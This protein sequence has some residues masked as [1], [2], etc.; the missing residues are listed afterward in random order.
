MNVSP[1]ISIE[2]VIGSMNYK[3]LSQLL[4]DEL[5]NTLKQLDNKSDI[6]QL[7]KIAKTLYINN[8]IAIQSSE[9]RNKIIDALPLNKAKELSIKLKFSL[10]ES[11]YKNLKALEW[12]KNREQDKALTSFFGIVEDSVMPP[13]IKYEDTIKPS[14]ALFD[15]QRDVVL[16]T[17][18]A[19]REHPHKTLLHMPTGSGKTRSSMHIIS[20]HLLEKAPTLVCWLASSAELLEQAAEEAEK[21]WGKIGDREIKIYRFWGDRTIDL[22]SVKDGILVAGF[23][24]IYAAYQRDQNLII[25][26]GDRASLTVVDEAHQAIAPTYR[27]IIDTLSTKRPSNA[28]LGLSATPG[29]TWDDI[30]VD[31]EL[32]EFFGDKKVTL[33]IKDYPDSVSYLISEGYLAKPIFRELKFDN[34]IDFSNNYSQEYDKYSDISEKAL[35]IIAENS[36]RNFKI[37]AAIEELLTRHK[38]VIVFSASVHHA[39]LLSSILI[40]R[41]HESMVVTGATPQA[42]RERIIRKFKSK[43]H[44]NPMILCNFGV[45]TTGFDAPMTSAV[46]IARPTRSLVLYSQMVG[47]AIR[48]PRAGGNSEAEIVT[49]VDT[50]LPGFGSV[51]EAFINWEDVWNEYE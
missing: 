51:T 44:T 33:T 25:S 40:A 50:A 22:N 24:K 26:L 45:L 9:I 11:I 4:G 18:A 32:S 10:E 17:L 8:P 1:G 19:L 3:A 39:N 41:G 34:K 7:R 13:A 31:A 48:G 23:K 46:V 38:R 30:G 2:K 20:R 5:I 6:D 42:R 27:S 49:V 29:R 37:L 21:S 12:G 16:R 47:R 15:Y 36:D 28:L 14:Y 35:N 43:N